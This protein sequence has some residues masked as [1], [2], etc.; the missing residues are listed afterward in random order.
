MFMQGSNVFSLLNTILSIIPYYFL[1]TVSFTILCHQVQ[2]IYGAPGYF[3][4][5][6]V[7]KTDQV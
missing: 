2:E 1:V 3:V 6:E 4:E 5:S 7:S